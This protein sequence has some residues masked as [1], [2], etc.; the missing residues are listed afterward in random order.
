M[1]FSGHSKLASI[2]PKTNFGCP[3]D[4]MCCVG[5]VSMVMNNLNV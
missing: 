4:T 3:E 2:C 1:S 5:S